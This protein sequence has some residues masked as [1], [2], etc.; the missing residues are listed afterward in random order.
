MECNQ[1]EERHRI[2][3]NFAKVYSQLEVMRMENGLAQPSALLP[4]CQSL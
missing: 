3:K 4:K 1:L 2:A